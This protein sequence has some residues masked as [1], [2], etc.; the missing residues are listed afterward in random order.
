MSAK[1]ATHLTFQVGFF[2]QKQHGF[3]GLQHLTVVGGGTEHIAIISFEIGLVLNILDINDHCL[4][5]GKADSFCNELSN[6]SG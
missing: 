2:C 6:I 3:H 5:A 4:I 1:S